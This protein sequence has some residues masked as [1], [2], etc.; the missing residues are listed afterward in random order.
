[1]EAPTKLYFSTRDIN[2]ILDIYSDKE[3]NDTIEYVRKDVVIEK[4]C[5]FIRKMVDVTHNIECKDGQ[6]LVDDYIKYAEERLKAAE[7]IVDDF[8]KYMKGE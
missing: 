8:K 7:K 5:D 3:P 2:G 6:P 1:M 4:T